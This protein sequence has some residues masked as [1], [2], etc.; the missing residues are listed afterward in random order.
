MGR[1]GRFSPE[2]RER[3]VRMVLEHENEHTSQWAAITSIAQ[4]IG[5]AS[6]CRGRP[7]GG[8]LTRD[9]RSLFACG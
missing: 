7:R 3:A 9:G 8:A 6:R 5:C 2:V 4:K 1:Q